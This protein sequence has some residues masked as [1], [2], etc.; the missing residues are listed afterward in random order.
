MQGKVLEVISEM[1][2]CRNQTK[3]KRG[4]AVK[5][6]TIHS[7]VSEKRETNIQHE[8]YQS[9]IITEFL[10]FSISLFLP[11]SLFQT[12]SNRLFLESESNS[13]AIAKQVK[14]ATGEK[15]GETETRESLFR[16]IL[17]H[18]R[19]FASKARQGETTTSTRIW[20]LVLLSAKKTRVDVEHRE[21]RLLSSSSPQE[22][23]HIS[24]KV[25]AVS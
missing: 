20:F 5:L 3:Q 21:E 14:R 13:K 17:R 2:Y 8:S 12:E 11:R 4:V 18:H 7:I 23:S 10:S 9:V 6:L 25:R 16:R 1:M 19:Q 24:T 22:L 15:R